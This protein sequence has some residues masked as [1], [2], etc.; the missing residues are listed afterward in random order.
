LENAVR[1][2]IANEKLKKAFLTGCVYGAAGRFFNVP[3]S[4]FASVKLVVR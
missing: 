4:G 3:I 2:Q 1:V